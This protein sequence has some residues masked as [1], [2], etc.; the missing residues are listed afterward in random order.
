MMKK[1]S[2]LRKNRF[3]L[4]ERHFYQNGEAQ[5]MLV[6]ADRIVIQPLTRSIQ[7]LFN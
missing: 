7:K 2:N 6:V 3:H 1:Q 4:L 5:K